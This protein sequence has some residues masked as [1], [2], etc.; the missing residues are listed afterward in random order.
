MAANETCEMKSV[1]KTC[2]R[3]GHE[4]DCRSCQMSAQNC[5]FRGFSSDLSSFSSEASTGASGICTACQLSAPSTRRCAHAGAQRGEQPHLRGQ[6]CESLVK[7]KAGEVHLAISSA[8]HF[9]RRGR[10]G[11]GAALLLRS[12]RRH[13]TVSIAL[14][15]EPQDCAWPAKSHVRPSAEQKGGIAAHH[16]EQA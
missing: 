15:G 4:I 12:R 13:R 8:W 6:D 10:L 14:L 11:D 16:G 3:D 5:G 7:V 2:L 1:W 9:D